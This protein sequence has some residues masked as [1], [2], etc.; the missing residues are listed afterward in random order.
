M[1]YKEDCTLPK[2]Y[3]EQLSATG[4]ETLPEMIRLL[5]NEAMQIERTEHN[6]AEPYQRKGDRRGH[7]NGFKPKTV[8][9]RMGEITFDVPQVREGGFY[10]GALE[11]GLRSERALTMTLAE[12]YVQ[13]VF[14][15]KSSSHHRA[16]MRHRSIRQS[17]QSGN[18]TIG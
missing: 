16:I 1:I 4:L 12:M 14:H 3:L 2:E 9:T 8:K 6:Q 5:I 15:P 7:S 13:G 10:P 18:R 11:K 17:G